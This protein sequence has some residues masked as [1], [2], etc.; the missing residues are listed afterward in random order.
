MR[1]AAWLLLLALPAPTARPCR[2]QAGTPAVTIRV[3]ADR[4]QGPLPPVWRFFGADEPNFATMKDGRALLAELGALRPGEVYFRAHNLLTSGDGTPALK[5][6]ST[7]AYT[8]D[9]QGRPAY[10]WTI[11]DRI[12]DTYLQRRVKPY[13]QIGFMPKELST[14]PEPY[15][16]D[17]RP[18]SGELF[19]GWSYPPKDYAKWAEL[20]TR[21]V[22]HCVE[23]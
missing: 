10:D 15:Q 3:D 1:R 9:A 23:R 21:W 4:D 18:G 2:A 13:V 7:N 11:V 22:A 16:H 17:W 14:R 6:G 20:V 8:E 12:F 19:T 5:W